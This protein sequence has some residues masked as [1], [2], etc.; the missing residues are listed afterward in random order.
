MECQHGQTFLYQREI[1][2]RSGGDKL[3]HHSLFFSHNYLI[4]RI[5]NSIIRDV[6]I[7]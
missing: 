4:G 1:K 5:D 2:N 7:Y 3:S 6:L